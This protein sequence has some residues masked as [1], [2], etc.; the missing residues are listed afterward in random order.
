MSP[1]YISAVSANELYEAMDWR[2]PMELSSPLTLGNPAWDDT[3]RSG[4]CLVQHSGNVT[5]RCGIFPEYLEDSVNEYCRKQ[6]K[7]SK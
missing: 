4:W 1:A 7:M 2:L 6:R 5:L 3:N